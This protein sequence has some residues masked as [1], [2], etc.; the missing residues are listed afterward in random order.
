MLEDRLGVDPSRTQGLTTALLG[1]HGFFSV[2][3]GPLIAHYA[4]KAS[5]KRTPL[6]FSLGGCLLGTI[7]VA[8]CFSLWALF[9]GRIL[10]AVAGSAV[11]IVGFATLADTVGLGNMG[12]ILGVAMSFVTGGIL[13]GPV[14]AGTL[15]QLT[16]YW[17]TWSVPLAI[18]IIDIALRL[19]MIEKPK[20]STPS[21]QGDGS[22]GQAGETTGLLSGSTNDNEPATSES[23]KGSAFDFYRIMLREGR[24]IV[25]LSSSVLY[26]SLLSSFETTLPLHVRE[27]FG[28]GSLPAGMMFFC[29]QIPA[30]VLN[31]VSGFLRDR[32]GLRYPVTVAFSL[33]APLLWLLG[34][35]GDAS[36][37]WASADTRGKAIYVATICAAGCVAPFIHGV[38]SM[39]LAGQFFRLFCYHPPN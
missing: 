14:V 7:L 32:Y 38:G 11:W 31:P 5:N 39:E 6:L 33:M 34:V 19:I 35:P 36:F 3:S 29:L 8:S 20:K 2:I 1:I 18:L 9:L 13:G 23:A 22:G 10:Q 4:D 15:L 26:S 24:V 12:K 30:V 21:H 27:V 17:V 16:G 28:W 37:P 25:A